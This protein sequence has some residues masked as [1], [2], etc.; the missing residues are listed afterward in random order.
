MR[1]LSPTRLQPL[2]PPEA[3]ADPEFQEV[4]RVLAQMPRP[5]K[6]RG[7]MEQCP[8]GALP[9]PTRTRQYQQL[10]TRLLHRPPR[11]EENPG[12]PEPPQV[13]NDEAE[14][15]RSPPPEPPASPLPAPELRSALR[16]ASSPRR[17]P[18]ARVRLN[19]L[20]LLLDAALTGELDVV[21]QAVAELNDP[22]QPN[23]EGITALHNAICGANYAIVDFLIAC[24]ADVNSP[25]S[26]GWT[27]L[28]C[29][30]SCN[31]TAICVAL[32]RHGAAVYATTSSDG[33]LAVDKC[34]PYREG[35]AECHSYLTEVEQSLGQ[36]HGGVVYALW[37][38]A[39][40]LGDELGFREGDPVTVLRRQPP[41]EH[42][43]WWA[44]LR[45]Q[46][47]FVPRCYFGLF[48]RVRPQ[49]KKV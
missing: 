6:R 26:H 23:D 47:G 22:S 16:S 35:Y 46:E 13:P 37:D 41:G 43:W 44:A 10:I 5:L 40:A 32:V 45:G 38:Y 36:R 14:P 25:D 4:A 48:P 28:H 12:D 21:Q 49:R 20:V 42:E 27:P 24:G 18:G 3:R 1:P 31:D 8:G 9:P 29:A 15:P 11:R 34:D 19:P 7:S 39:A 2:L 30:A 17:R 33:C